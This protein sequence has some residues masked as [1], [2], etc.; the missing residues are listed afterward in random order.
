MSPAP[1]LSVFTRVLTSENLQA[2]RV[3]LLVI[4]T[5]HGPPFSQA[6]LPSLVLSISSSTRSRSSATTDEPNLDGSLAH[7]TSAVFSSCAMG[8]LVPKSGFVQPVLATT[9]RY[10]KSLTFTPETSLEKTWA[11]TSSKARTKHTISTVLALIHRAAE[12]DFKTQWYRHSGPIQ[13]EHRNVVKRRD[14]ECHPQPRDLLKVWPGRVDHG[15]NF[16]LPSRSPACLY[17]PTTRTSLTCA[18]AAVGRSVPQLNKR[19]RCTTKALL[20][21]LTV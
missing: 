13:A 9:D 4:R 14:S 15:E 1:P 21:P 10:V 11:P 19:Q 7:E 2:L 8:G 5:H 3:A 17:A 20:A 18:K 16:P 6:S 12:A